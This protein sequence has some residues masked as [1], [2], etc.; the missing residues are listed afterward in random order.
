MSQRIAARLVRRTTA[1][2]LAH[3]VER[4]DQDLDLG[5]ESRLELADLFDVVVTDQR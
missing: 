5:G 1:R 2:G 3:V 4:S